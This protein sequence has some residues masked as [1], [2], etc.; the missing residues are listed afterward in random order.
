MSGRCMLSQ[1]DR[2][3]IRPRALTQTGPGLNSRTEPV[4]CLM[5]QKL[6]HQHPPPVPCGR[7]RHP[8]APGRAGRSANAFRRQAAAEAGLP[9]ARRRQR[10]SMS[11]L[12]ARRVPPLSSTWGYGG[13]AVHP[14]G[15]LG[16]VRVLSQRLGNEHPGAARAERRSGPGGTGD[17]GFVTES[18]LEGLSSAGQQG[19]ASRAT[20][21][22]SLSVEQAAPSGSPETPETWDGPHGTKGPRGAE[23]GMGGEQGRGGKEGGSVLPV[24][25]GEGR[26]GGDMEW[27][28]EGEADTTPPTRGHS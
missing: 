17:P 11:Q 15:H 22:L 13:S 16:R 5:V 9:T 28:G 14:S 25:L 24:R 21:H 18:H 4:I 23:W 10:K 12:R 8:E 20:Q 3:N 1:G 26:C 2:R 7:S 27:T 6:P 19:S